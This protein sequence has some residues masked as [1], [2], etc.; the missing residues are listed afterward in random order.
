MGV[1]G[2]SLL[3]FS[4]LVGAMMV[5]GLF[6]YVGVL[7]QL[8]Y[9][10]TGYFVVPSLPASLQSFLLASAVAVL[11]FYLGYVASA[12]RLFAAPLQTAFLQP[13]RILIGFSMFFVLFYATGQGF[14]RA[15]DFALLFSASSSL[16][17]RWGVRSEHRKIEESLVALDAAVAAF[18]LLHLLGVSGSAILLTA[19]IYAAFFIDVS[20][21]WDAA[22]IGVAI[23]LW[24]LGHI[25]PLPLLFLLGAF[26]HHRVHG[27][28]QHWLDP[29]VHDVLPLYFLFAFAGVSYYSMGFSSVLLF[30]GLL[31]ISY[32]QNFVSLVV[33][34]PV[35]GVPPR[36]GAHMVVRSFGPS[37][38]SLA[39][40][41]LS[42][43]LL[44]P[45]VILFY[46]VALFVYSFVKTD[47]D[48]ERFVQLLLPS[49]IDR[50]ISRFESSYSK[51][52]VKNRALL[53]PAFSEATM[54]TASR[55][56]AALLVALA[57]FYVI[58]DAISVSAQHA[59]VHILLG[60]AFLLVAVA[61]LVTSYVDL[62]ER[63]I[64]FLS[65]FAYGRFLARGHSVYG[66]VG[67]Y[68]ATFAGFF[69]MPFTIPTAN[70]VLIFFAL[71]LLSFGMY[72]LLSNYYRIV[73]AMVSGSE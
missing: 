58:V 20:P 42:S 29:I 31:A 5:G 10:L 27:A 39:A 16:I 65:R 13:A 12:R 9:L 14:S 73:R 41:V 35:F 47:A 23:I 26:I 51:I 66:L 68:L 67:G 45:A 61:V 4:I 71:L 30:L 7:P 48:A 8:G 3:L 6:Q 53:S 19:V 11:L 21:F 63:A 18:A 34:G 72:A 28:A 17:L 70:L 49:S 44:S 56:F 1:L 37:E 24:A 62:Y 22:V 59:V 40:A 2:S 25:G 69:I 55:I 15:V 64:D 36:T 46:S 43:P 52:Y 54:G 50:M 32:L 60:L 38:A 57:S 33:L